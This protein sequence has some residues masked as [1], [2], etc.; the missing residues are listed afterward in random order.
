MQWQGIPTSLDL[1]GRHR[2]CV[3]PRLEK[4]SRS[5]RVAVWTERLSELRVS[6]VQRYRRTTCRVGE[7]RG[8]AADSPPQ[9]SALSRAT[10]V[11]GL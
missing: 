7:E 9:V 2:H 11:L 3:C 4:A 6:E 8:K 1:C 5:R 10:F